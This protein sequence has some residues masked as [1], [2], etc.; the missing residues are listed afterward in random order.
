MINGLNTYHLIFGSAL[1]YERFFINSTDLNTIV[2]GYPCNKTL[3]FGDCAQS[4]HTL[5]KDLTCLN[6]DENNKLVCLCDAL[7]CNNSS[8]LRRIGLHNCPQLNSLFC[9]SRSCSFVT[10]ICNLK[11]LIIRNLASLMDVC[12]DNVVDRQS[13]SQGGIFSFL[14][15]F[16][17]T[18]CHLIKRLFTPQ[19][20]QQLQ[21]L[22]K[23]TVRNCD[24]ML[25]IFEGNNSDDNDC[26][27]IA[28]P[29]LTELT[30]S[31]LP[32][33]NTVCRGSLLCG[34][35]PK[36]GIHNCPKLQRHPTI[37]VVEIPEL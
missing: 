15:K 37:E 3:Q 2:R 30:L 16:Y 9:L 20:V 34:S 27:N 12:K 29:K 21:N 8:S 24:S 32:Q 17:I 4:F 13:L 36:V 11:V 35:S 31:R 6:I 22:K 14:T 23:L 28:L 1:S 19:L 7:S 26:T 25:A 18:E 10:N 33:L 5:P